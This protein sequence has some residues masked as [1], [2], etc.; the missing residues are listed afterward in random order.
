MINIVKEGSCDKLS[1]A[2]SRVFQGGILKSIIRDKET[3]LSFYM[4][5]QIVST[6]DINEIFDNMYLMNRAKSRKSRA[7][8]HISSHQK[9]L[10]N[11]IPKQK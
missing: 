4:R 9:K 5:K 1:Y 3:L 6:N 7:E 8:V 2:V 10:D 11:L